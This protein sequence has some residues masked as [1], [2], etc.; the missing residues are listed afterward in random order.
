MNILDGYVYKYLKV[1]QVIE[2]D[3]QLYSLNMGWKEDPYSS[4]TNL[5]II[6]KGKPEFSCLRCGEIIVDV[7]AH[8]KQHIDEDDG[9]GLIKDDDIEPMLICPLCNEMMEMAES[10]QKGALPL[11]CTCGYKRTIRMFDDGKYLIL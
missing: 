9:I 5:K 11:V 10:E 7:Y 2:V 4:C 6:T 1:N 8:M 3:Y